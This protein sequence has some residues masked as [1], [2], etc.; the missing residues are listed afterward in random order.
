MMLSKSNTF[1]RAGGRVDSGHAA[2]RGLQSDDR[3]FFSFS[4]F[5]AQA[6]LTSLLLFLS[7]AVA[8]LNGHDTLVPEM[9][10]WFVNVRIVVTKMTK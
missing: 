8:E 10:P 1:E 6:G 5:F 9:E 7:A 3:Y 4:F 2:L